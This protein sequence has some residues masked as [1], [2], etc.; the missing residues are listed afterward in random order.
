MIKHIGNFLAVI[1]MLNSLNSNAIEHYSGIDNLPIYIFIITL[2]GL[3]LF[4]LYSTLRLNLS[5]NLEI[6]VYLIIIFSFLFIPFWTSYKNI[7]ICVGPLAAYF[8]LYNLSIESIKKI[9]WF[10]LVINLPIAL[11]EYFTISYLYDVVGD[12]YGVDFVIVAYSDLMR[13]KALFA[14]CLG[15][16]YFAVFASFIFY[17]DIKII[18]ISL[19]LCLLAGT[20][21]PLVMVLFVFLLYLIT[22]LS[23]KKVLLTTLIGVIIL[24]FVSSFLQQSSIDRIFM[25]ADFQNDSSNSL[26]IFYWILGITTYFFEYDLLHQAFGNMGYFQEKIG[27]NAESAW[28]TMFLDIGFIITFLYVIMFIVIS[29]KLIIRRKYKKIFLLSMVFVSMWTVP[30]IYAFNQNI[31]FWIFILTILDDIKYEKIN[32]FGVFKLKK[33]II[34]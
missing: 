19:V 14:S 9:T 32:T 15:L 26:R 11:Y 4:S 30:L 3:I 21:Q 16:G 17:D 24:A 18:S 34:Q 31:Y 13:A 33:L 6:I 12:T 22:H 5:N 27:Y 1:M 28:I 10:F 25:T 8:I 20:R 2:F 29:Y 7:I 23:G